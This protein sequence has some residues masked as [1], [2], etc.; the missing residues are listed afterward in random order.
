MDPEEYV[1]WKALA[2]ATSWSA[3][4]AREDSEGKSI[5]PPNGDGGWVLQT[6]CLNLSELPQ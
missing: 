4:R 1:L 5:L 3:G 6:K 2:R